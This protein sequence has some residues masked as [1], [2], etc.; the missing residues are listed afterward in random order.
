MKT[1]QKCNQQKSLSEFRKLK[2]SPD[3]HQSK[4]KQCAR[5][6][7]KKW[8][9]TNK[10]ERKGRILKRNKEA[11]ARNRKFVA[12]Y[13]LAHPCVDCGET[14]ILVLEFDHRENK[15]L[16]I[17]TML[18]SAYSLKALQVEIN[19]CDVRCA[20]CHRIKTLD[21]R[22]S[23]RIKYASEALQAMQGICTPQNSVRFRTEAQR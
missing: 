9:G 7:D 14:N 17:G 3:G 19:K 23:W 20:N 11:N 15:R 1:C 5:I 6:Y 22:S 10:L 21:E 4:C 8:Y 13:L 12:E 18:C 16:D 2:R